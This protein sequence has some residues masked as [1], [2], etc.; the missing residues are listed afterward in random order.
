M[1]GPARRSWLKNHLSEELLRQYQ[2]RIFGSHRALTPMVLT[3]AKHG[4]VGASRASPR[5]ST[6][7]CL[8]NVANFLY[9]WG[10]LKH[11]WV[12]FPLDSALWFPCSLWQ[13]YWR[14]DRQLSRPSPLAL[15]GSQVKKDFFNT[16][17]ILVTSTE[18]L[19]FPK[20][21]NYSPFY[22]WFEVI[23]LF[24]CHGN[25]QWIKINSHLRSYSSLP[26]P[27]PA[28]CIDSL[29]S[30]GH[31]QSCCSPALFEKEL[32]WWVQFL[33]KVSSVSSLL[34]WETNQGHL[35]HRWWCAGLLWRS[36]QPS[37]V[38]VTTM[39]IAV[40]VTAGL[41]AAAVL[42]RWT[43]K[44]KRKFT[45]GKKQKHDNFFLKAF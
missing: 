35:S 6:V 9:S 19:S 5:R 8:Q 13:Q 31:Y 23:S 20:T 45:L 3:G 21:E 15:S 41:V 11:V 42:F 33:R 27:F 16:V 25:G 1:G 4:A 17:L 30:Q 18:L 34:F 44:R 26:L 40:L 10:M 14:K 37:A 2:G 24:L 28:A 43:W 32:W 7:L 39:K 29:S 36:L 38:I 12:F 22:S